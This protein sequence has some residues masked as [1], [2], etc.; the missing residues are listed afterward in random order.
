MNQ[1]AFEPLFLWVEFCTF[2]ANNKTHN[3]EV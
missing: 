1:A 3:H 2:D